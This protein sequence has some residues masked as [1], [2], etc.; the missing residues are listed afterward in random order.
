MTATVVGL[1]CV[2]LGAGDLLV[3]LSLAIKW[4]VLRPLPPKDM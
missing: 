1:T 4:G 3:C 2:V